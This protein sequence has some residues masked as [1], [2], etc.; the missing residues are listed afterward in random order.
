MRGGE[1]MGRKERRRGEEIGREDNRGYEMA[2][3][4]EKQKT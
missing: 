2:R 1:E 4:E 3:G